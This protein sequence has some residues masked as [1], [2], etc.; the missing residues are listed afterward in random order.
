MADYYPL[1]ARAVAGLDSNSTG[2]SRRAL[3]ER[4]RSALIA[5]LRGVQ[6]PL[7]EAEITRERLALEEAVRKVEA[8]A[9][10]RSRSDPQRGDLRNRQPDAAVRET[11]RRG[12]ALRESAR[13]ASARVAQHTAPSAGRV[14]SP[15]EERTAEERPA[16]NLRA[17]P[18]Q[19]PPRD[20]R[21]DPRSNAQ[22]VDQPPRDRD[23]RG[24]P[25]RRP[26]DEDRE[27]P[28]TRSQNPG[29]TPGSSHGTRG[30]RDVVADADDLGRAASQANRSARRTY[31]NVPSPSPEFD[32]VEPDMEQR[33]G[34]SPYGYDEAFDEPDD[35]YQPPQKRGKN[36]VWDKSAKP[37]KSSK[38]GRKFPI[39]I[40]LSVGL[41]LITIGVAILLYQKFAPSLRAMFKSS[42]AVDTSVSGDPGARPKITDRVGQPD[43]ASSPIAP[44]AQRAILFEEDPAD[45]QG[46]QTVGTVVWR[47]DQIPPSPKQKPDTAI[48]AD[49][50]LPDRKLKVMLTIMRNTDP[51]MPATSH[52]IE[53]VYTVTPEFGTTIANVPGIYAKSQDQP[54]GTPLAA[55]SVK[56]QDGYFLI[57]LSNVDVD[58]DRNLQV[59]KERSSLDIPMVYGNQKRAILSLEKGAPGD[60]VF[61]DAFA[62][63]GQ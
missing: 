40:A 52:T 23:L 60:R 62:A 26:H 29:P 7:S 4:A 42:P 35:D 45:P 27:L 34:P 12:D 11:P 13:A 56:V 6:P 24:L 5:Q 46:K 58:R 28:S 54:R 43:S 53:V 48:R 2:E 16:R 55:T 10:Q 17:D 18:T 41:A 15:P 1:I 20:L 9:A 49:I 63:W 30:F 37:A 51:S 25:P 57:G 50:E 21:S 59:L 33:G 36:S 8:E 38:T 3:Y 61:R 19:R 14:S 32:R 44:V 39:K 22:D 47:L 31:A